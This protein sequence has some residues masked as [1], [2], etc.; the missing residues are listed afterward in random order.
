M[1]YIRC[2]PHSAACCGAADG[3][4]LDNQ[5]ALPVY[6]ECQS[7]GIEIHIAGSLYFQGYGNLFA[8]EDAP[9]DVRERIE[10][11]EGLAAKHGGL[12]LLEVSVRRRADPQ[13]RDGCG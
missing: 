9:D 2:C 8:K 4:N 5:S 1:A 12:T 13:R 6:S 11:W 7:R 3:W 10:Q